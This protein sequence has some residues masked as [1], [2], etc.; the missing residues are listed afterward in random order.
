[1]GATSREGAPSLE[2]K[3][4]GTLVQSTGPGIMIICS[5]KNQEINIRGNTPVG[6]FA[7]VLD[8]VSGPG[9]YTVG[10]S[11]N[12]GAG[13]MGVGKMYEVKK[14]GTPFTVT[15]DDVEELTAINAPEAK[16]IRGSFHGKLM[17]DSGNLVDITDGK[18][19]TQ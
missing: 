6:M 1:M 7:I 14:T 3:M 9:T 10:K 12:N 4:D 8:H 17:G 16:A 5:P 19:S 18:F 11:A 13:I 2:F 15:V